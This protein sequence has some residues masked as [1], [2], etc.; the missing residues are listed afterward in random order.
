[1]KKFRNFIVCLMAVSLILSVAGCNNSNKNG[2]KTKTKETAEESQ[3]I[4]DE[5]TTETTK[6]V[7]NKETAAPSEGSSTEPTTEPSEEITEGISVD[8]DGN[9]D[10]GFT[11]GLVLIDNI[12]YAFTKTTPDMIDVKGGYKSTPDYQGE[13]DSESKDRL[14]GVSYY[15]CNGNKV[16]F[17]R[18]DENG[19]V[20]RSEYK[21]YDDQGMLIKEENWSRDSY[22]DSYFATYEYDADGLLSI[23]HYGKAS[24]YISNTS[25]FEYDEQ[26]RVISKLNT[27]TDSDDPNYKYEYTYNDDGSFKECYLGF[28]MISNELENSSEGYKLYNADGLITEYYT[29]K[30]DNQY[31]YYSYDENGRLVNEE[32]YSGDLFK[33][34]TVYT[35]DEEGR[36]IQ[37]DKYSASGN[38][39]Y[40]MVYTIEEM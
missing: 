4:E 27:I 6:D 26:G 34:N 12:D 7:H 17:V 31:V 28:S 18:Y 19:D 25:V 9:A 22:Q 40:T 38:I 2:R 33:G 36:L 13:D 11:Q 21:I 35:Y 10:L 15:D 23:V 14:F 30:L 32:D 5:E 1:M 24:G 37:K 16:L 8:A 29:G 3:T 20:V 39:S